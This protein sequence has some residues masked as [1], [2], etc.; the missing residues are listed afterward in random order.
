MNSGECMLEIVVTDD[1]APLKQRTA[2]QWMD[3]RVQ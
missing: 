1:L 2:V 3:F